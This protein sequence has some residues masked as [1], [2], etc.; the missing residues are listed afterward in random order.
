MTE[1]FPWQRMMQV[2]LGNLR[3]SPDQFWRSS[4]REIAAAWG[5]PPHPKLLRQDLNEMMEK[6]PDD[7]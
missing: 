3:L 5:V 6:Y 1:T 2:G 7:K 4:P